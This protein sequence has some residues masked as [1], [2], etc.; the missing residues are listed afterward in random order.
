MAFSEF[1]DEFRLVDLPLVGGPFTWSNGRSP[2]TLSQL[3]RFLV[4]GE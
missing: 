2:P 4:S 3:D 1:I